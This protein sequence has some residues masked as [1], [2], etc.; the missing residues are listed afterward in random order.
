MFTPVTA[1]KSFFNFDLSGDIDCHSTFVLHFPV[2]LY[3]PCYKRVAPG[4]LTL[5]CR[6]TYGC[7]AELV[8]ASYRLGV[9]LDFW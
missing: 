4:V 9:L 6:V 3:R 5:T 7:H 2:T 8:S 1:R